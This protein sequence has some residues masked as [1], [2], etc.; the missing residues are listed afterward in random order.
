[1]SKEEIQQSIAEEN[2]ALQ[3]L[4]SDFIAKGGANDVMQLTNLLIAVSLRSANATYQRIREDI[5]STT[6]RGTDRR[7]GSILA[8]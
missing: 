1:M 3:Q 5:F 8:P 7:K 4:A 6:M 2:E